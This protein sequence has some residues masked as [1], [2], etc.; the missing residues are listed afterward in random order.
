M[1][2]KFAVGEFFDGNRVL[3]NGWIFNP[4]GMNGRASA[5]DF[6]LKFQLTAM[7][8]NAGRFDMSALDHVGLAG[9]SPLSAVTFV[10]NH[11]TDLTSGESV[12]FNKI[13]GYAYILTSEG[14]PCVYY[15]D[16]DTGPDGYKLKPQID[17]LIWIHEKLAAGP[18]QQRWKDF[19]VFA[20]E[21]LGGPHLLVGLNND[22]GG[23]R[24]I[25]VA[26]GFGP[27]VGLHDYAGH[28]GERHYRWQR[29]RDHHHST[30]R[31]RIG[32]CVL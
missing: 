6:P 31:Q 11:D 14:Y 4:R 27:N 13:L 29:Q 22:P 12:V 7:C 20:Y 2:G 9:M 30:K 24:T 17:N 1:A 26:T 15:R 5:F 25:T 10:E 21:R 18:T 32:I 16:Y 23:P 28:A 8:N 3:V 19:D